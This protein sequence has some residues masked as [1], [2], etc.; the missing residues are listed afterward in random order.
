MALTQLAASFAKEAHA[1][2]RRPV[3]RPRRREPLLTLALVGAGL[4]LGVVLGLPLVDGTLHELDAPGG[5]LLFS[6]SVTGLVGA[7]LTLCM[8]LLA[9]RIPLVERTVGRGGAMMWHRSISVA[10]ITLLA[11]HALLVTVADARTARVGVGRELVTLIQAYPWMLE[12]TI[13]LGLM[14]VIGLVSLPLARSRVSRESWWLLHLT[15][16]A[17]LVLALLH[18][19]AL[20]PSFVNHPLATAVWIAVWALAG[21]AVLSFRIVLPAIRSLRHDLRVAEVDTTDPRTVT[22]VLEGRR[23]ER[24]DIRGGQF[25][26]WRFLSRG[27]WYQA[28]PFSVSG[29]PTRGL[30][31]LTIKRAG[32][33][34]DRLA[35]LSPGTRVAFEG[36]YGT[37]TSEARV[38]TKALLIA[39]GMGV[40]AIR[41]LLVDLPPEA[42]PVVVLRV[43][44]RSH[45]PLLEEIEALARVRKG[46]V[47]LLAG[48]RYEVDLAVICD[49]IPDFAERDI[50]MAGPPGLLDRLVSLLRQLGVPQRALHVE[51]YAI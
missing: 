17:A 13:A 44:D 26:E 47:Y 20:G 43:H 3:A 51:P 37:L 35:N 25:F 36:P 14:L 50:F 42:E 21:L 7:Y 6:G 12:A 41:G 31:R 11:A 10:A 24:L 34:T 16:Y 29:G 38:R 2:P 8:V 46:E 22:V 49:R 45:V 39:G 23:L 15:I 30:L 40:T 9:A 48:G 5:A 4:G 28:H 27:R 19:L 33:F 18:E 32:D 1:R